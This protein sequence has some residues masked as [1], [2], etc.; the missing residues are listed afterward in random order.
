MT[1]L[2]KIKRGIEKYIRIMD[3][4]RETDVSEND[5]FQHI[6]NGFYQVRRNEEW[7]KVFYSFMEERKNKKTGIEEIM[8][9]LANNTPWKSVELSFASK[10]LHT[11][12]KDAPIYDKKVASFLKLKGP[13][14]SWSNEKKIKHQVETYNTIIAWYQTPRAKS[15]I[16]LFDEIFPE[17]KTKIGDVKKIDFIIWRGLSDER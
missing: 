9:Y 11:I 13:V 7:R 5:E 8:T 10:L 12:D 17:Y 16:H 1:E 3:L 4:I 14:V 15:L 2:E 6:F